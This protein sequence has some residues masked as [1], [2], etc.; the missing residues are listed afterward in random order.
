MIPEYVDEI[1]ERIEACGYRGYIVGGCVRDSLMGV[2][3]GDY[4][5]T[6]N[7]MPDET[8][9][10]LEGYKII[11]TGQRYGTLTVF[12]GNGQVEITTHRL[13]GE[14]SDNRHPDHVMYT[15]KLEDD[16]NRR[17][18][19]VNAMAYSRRTGII[20]MHSGVRHIKEKIITC[21]G[22]SDLR[23]REDGLRILRALRFS[24]VLCFGISEETDAAL[25]RNRKILAGISAERI[26]SELKKL[27]CGRDAGRVLLSFPEVFGEI[28][29]EISRMDMVRTA[30]IYRHAGPDL[31]I[32]LAVFFSFA[33]NIKE[34]EY[35]LRR[36]KADIRTIHTVCELLEGLKDEF[37]AD[38]KK[39]KLLLGK[40][41]AE[42]VGQIIKLRRTVFFD[43]LSVI[44]DLKSAERLLNR[45]IS[46][47][48]CVSLKT[49]AV[50]GSDL[51]KLGLR[52]G[53]D[54]GR[55]LDQLLG[56]VIE[57]KA[58][59]EKEKLLAVIP[60]LK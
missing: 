55:I 58:E 41:S 40:I 12:S 23:F 28:I 50:S 22:N 44:R 27:I 33:E 8:E 53:P 13:D 20:D 43:D 1:I 51:I 56:L 17:D 42:R 57:S 24:G 16:L 38:E 7:S 47:N 15:R 6:V 32:R 60:F 34:C 39:I 48:A 18:F 26:C 45:I 37:G 3:P 14:Y 59:N 31:Y 9:A 46:E 4:D 29:P 25:R 30:D 49:L 2:S 36:L 11:R 21:V 10:C 5:I 54:I 19:T 35:M 52:E